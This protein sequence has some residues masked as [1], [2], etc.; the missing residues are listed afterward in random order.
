MRGDN[1]CECVCWHLRFAGVGCET[2]VSLLSSKQVVNEY[3]VAHD[4]A[5]ND[6]PS[7]A[8][9][10]VFTANHFH[11]NKHTDTHLL[12][13]QVS[14]THLRIEVS[15]QAGFRVHDLKS[16]HGAVIT[17]PAPPAKKPPP[18]D[19]PPPPPKFF[20]I[21]IP[22][23]PE[24]V[25]GAHG[26]RITLGKTTFV[27][28]REGGREPL[29]M[30]RPPRRTGPAGGE[31]TVGEVARRVVE[32]KRPAAV[33]SKRFTANPNLV[34]FNVGCR[35]ERERNEVVQVQL[36]MVRS[37]VAREYGC[38]L[39]LAIYLSMCSASPGDRYGSRCTERPQVHDEPTALIAGATFAPP[40]CKHSCR[41]PDCCRVPLVVQT[42]SSL[43]TF[44]L[45]TE[46]MPD[47]LSGTHQLEA[48]RSAEEMERARKRKAA[49][50]EVAAAAAAE[51]LN[52][53]KR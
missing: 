53:S 52:N 51:Y 6:E 2:V 17:K 28:E 16:K 12:F 46:C 50:S 5:G 49:A 40:L 23:G 10:R 20:P 15:A 38:L 14:K 13:P 45:T 24:W 36:I 3:T 29:R 35:H 8:S 1:S 34:R 26:D 4:A 39:A 27:V 25:A 11:A 19:A 30:T 37:N 43:S 31:T 48:I 18:K 32:S 7:E 22:H 44:F 42:C 33:I 9:Q 21:P 47:R 41:G